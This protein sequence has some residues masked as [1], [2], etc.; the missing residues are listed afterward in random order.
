MEYTILIDVH[1][2]GIIGHIRDVD[3]DGTYDMFYNITT[4]VEINVEQQ[5][6]GTYLID[7]NG[8]GEWDHI[9]NI[10]TG[11]IANYDSTSIAQTDNTVIIAL[12][13][14]VIILLSISF[15]FIKWNQDKKNAPVN[16]TSKKSQLRGKIVTKVKNLKDKLPS[17]L[18]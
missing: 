8:D 5:K 1:I 15:L 6:G 10:E 7:E 9:Y 4:G 3:S 16:A 2:V 13:L 12:A 17:F 18:F 14:L 11:E